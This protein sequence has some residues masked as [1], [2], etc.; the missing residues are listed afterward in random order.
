[1]MRK[2]NM[3]S[4]TTIKLVVN[5]ELIE[6]RVGY[7]VMPWH[8]LVHTLRETLGL[9]GTKVG[10]N[11]GECGA[12]T[13]IMDGKPI[14]SCT[15]LTIECDGKKVTTIEGL[16]DPIQGILHPLQKAFIDHDGMQCGFCTPGMIMEA[17]AL[18]DKT[19]HPTE[20]QV[21]EALAGNLCRCG[22]Y[23]KIV[24]SVLAAASATKGA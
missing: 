6:L 1:M 19:S 10:C 20:R 12:C 21:K 9:T 5:G 11:N 24:E 14:L 13:V 18:L 23:Q 2:K 4:E 3:E 16:G 22:S 7:Q 15:T 8:T 17:K